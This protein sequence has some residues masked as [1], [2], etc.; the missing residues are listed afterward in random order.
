MPNAARQ[1]DSTAHAGTVVQGSGNTLINSLPASRVGD[2][3][4]CPLPAPMP[5]V[6]GPIIRGS[7]SVTINSIPAGRLGDL[8]SC[9]GPVDIIV[10]GSPNV[11]IGG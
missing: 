3:H 5:H 2:H 9:Q 6:G 4:V 11:I 10:M 8:A 7:A 1:G